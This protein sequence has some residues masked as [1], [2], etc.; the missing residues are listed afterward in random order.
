MAERVAVIIVSAGASSRMAGVDKVWADLGGLPVLGHSLRAADAL[1][2]VTDI[3]I[4]TG[5]RRHTEVEA[6][7]SHLH[8]TVRCVEGG[9]RRQDSVA[10]GIAAAVDADW[11]LVHDAARP[12]ASG[13][14]WAR[15]LQGA[16]SHGAVVPVA[17]VVDTVKRVD[18]NGRILETV[19][20]APL[21]LAQ[22]PQGFA[23]ALLRRAHR[24]VTADATD[25]ASMVE[26]LGQPVM[27]VAGDPA[28][29]KVTTPR[30][31]V[32]ARALLAEGIE[33]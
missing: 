24:E 20:R 13:E 28:N 19:D 18:A 7:A 22:T 5:A 8:M 21:R 27:T 15:V 1:V 30:D 31:L 3:I 25:D 23:G 32:V 9:A 14:V 17:P 11:Y 10:A 12:L 4:V 16:R 6:L 26:A 29:L 33:G 2:G